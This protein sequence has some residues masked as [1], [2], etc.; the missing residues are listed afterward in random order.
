M[1]RYWLGLLYALG[2]ILFFVMGVIA[3]SLLFN[4]GSSLDVFASG[5]DDDYDVMSVK[6][7]PS[8]YDFGEP[9]MVISGVGLSS[10]DVS[11]DTWYVYGVDCLSKKKDIS[12]LDYKIAA[13]VSANFYGGSVSD[14]IYFQAARVLLRGVN[15]FWERRVS[16]FDVVRYGDSCSLPLSFDDYYRVVGLDFVGVSLLQSLGGVWVDGELVNDYVVDGFFEDDLDVLVLSCWDGVSDSVVLY[17]EGE[18]FNFVYHLYDIVYDSCL[19]DDLFV[20]SA[21]LSL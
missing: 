12:S 13:Y 14:Y 20:P 1:R 16:S 2:L 15:D 17:Y 5:V 4:L 10:G 3:G 18:S 21:S 8:C 6:L 11:D 7:F 9:D 19:S